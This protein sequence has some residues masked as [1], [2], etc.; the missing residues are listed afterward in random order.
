MA[1]AAAM[2]LLHG[3]ELHAAPAQVQLPGGDGLIDVAAD[4]VH[5]A[6]R[7]IDI[8]DHVAM[9]APDRARAGAAGELR[10]DALAH[11]LVAGVG[12]RGLALMADQ[13]ARARS[14]C[15]DRT[16]TIEP[17]AGLAGQLG[18]AKGP[19]RRLRPLD[20]ASALDPHAARTEPH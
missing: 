10:P 9:G 15:G 19:L 13:I 1:C 3:R 8:R 5:L 14:G 12:E 11:R 16:R 17:V 4:D 18:R 7:R 20:L 2:A 6:R